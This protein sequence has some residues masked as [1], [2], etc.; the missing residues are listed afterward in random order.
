[1]SYKF[2]PVVGSPKQGKGYPTVDSD[3]NV[4][5]PGESKPYPP[6]K[7]HSL[8]LESDAE[9]ED[10]TDRGISSVGVSAPGSG[11]KPM[12]ERFQKKR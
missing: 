9:E 4:T 12:A 6:E 10:A 3:G 7:W 1:M 5:L 2:R 11:P 8:N